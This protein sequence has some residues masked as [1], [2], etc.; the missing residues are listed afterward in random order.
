MNVTVAVIES[1][2]KLTE[3]FIGMSCSIVSI[4]KPKTEY[5]FA[6]AYTIPLHG[7]VCDVAKN[8]Q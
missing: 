5:I 4:V 8:V 6:A 1:V 2:K 7:A 3:F